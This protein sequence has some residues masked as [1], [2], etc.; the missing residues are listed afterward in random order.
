MKGRITPACAGK[1]LLIFNW[2]RW[3]RDHPRVCGKDID[4][5]FDQRFISGSPPRVRERHLLNTFPGSESGITPACAGKTTSSAGGGQTS[6]DHPR[7]CGKDKLGIEMV[8]QYQGSPPR[9]R[10]RPDSKKTIKN[11]FRITPACA[12]K[13]LQFNRVDCV[14]RDHPRVCGKDRMLSY[15]AK[16]SLG[17]PPRV[18]ERLSPAYLM[19][20]T[21]GITPACAGKTNL[22]R[23]TTWI[24]WD[25]P[26]VCGKD[27][28]NQH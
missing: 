25:H 3:S 22:F 27:V 18:R 11:A 6:R 4:G 10:E 7:V 21:S 5:M 23:V 13:T 14:I 26:R 16:V 12:G 28:L 15:Q 17:S 24:E 8:F 9:V 1:T 20:W 19:G 2:V